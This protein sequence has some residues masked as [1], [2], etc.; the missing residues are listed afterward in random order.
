LFAGGSLASTLSAKAATSTIPIVFTTGNDPVRYGLVLSLNRP[1]GNVTGISFLVNQLNPK[2]LELAQ[3]LVSSSAVIAVLIRS[4][5][6]TYAEDRAE[7]E[8]AAAT[9][10]QRLLFLDVTSEHDFEMAFATASSRQVGA[11]LVYT[12]PFFNSHRDVLVALSVRYAIPAIYEL[13]DFVTA[14]GL[15]SYGTSISSA[16]RQAGIYAGRILKG[17]KPG[18]LPVMQSTKFEL[19]LN[20]KTAKSL[21]LEIPPR[22]LALADEVIE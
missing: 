3:Q 18:D 7:I 2:R 12:D 17:E 15:I 5:H 11:L 8:T 1:G 10:G 9:I 14:G 20:L 19:V 21:G 6:P 4:K 16:Y 13:R 22:L